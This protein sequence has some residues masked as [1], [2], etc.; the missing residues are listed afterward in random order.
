MLKLID[1][2]ALFAYCCLI[3]YLS[4]QPSIA[5]PM[6]FT[7]QDKLHHMG[8]YFLM[9][10]LFWRSMTQLHTTTMISFLATLSFCCLYG[11]TD[12]WHQS[13]VPGREA[14]LLDWVADTAG[15]LCALFLLLL[16]NRKV[17]A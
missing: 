2:T 16:T 1:F 9:G 3:Y 17:N 15:A 12:E 8:A 13:Y 14:D 11:A 6:L 10:I 5:V 4:A 7:H